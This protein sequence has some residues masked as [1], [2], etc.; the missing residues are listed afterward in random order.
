LENVYSTYHQYNKNKA[1]LHEI[2]ED[3]EAKIIQ[4]GS[5]LGSRGTG[6][7]LRA[8]CVLW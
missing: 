5:F 8:A 7:N 2:V 4:I 6:S 3:S 1:E